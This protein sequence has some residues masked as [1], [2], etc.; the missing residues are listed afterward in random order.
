MVSLHLAV[1][2]RSDARAVDHGGAMHVGHRALP[3]GAE[4]L[5]AKNGAEGVKGA[6]IA[7]RLPERAQP[8]V[9]LQ[10][11]LDHVGRIG[12]DARDAPRNCPR[13]DPRPQRRVGCVGAGN[14]GG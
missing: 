1:V 10:P 6:L 7:R 8:P 2:I 9:R 5:G 3:E 13:G 4:T 14:G 12:E 11:H